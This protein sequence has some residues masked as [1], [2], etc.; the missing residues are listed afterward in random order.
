MDI[1]LFDKIIE[2]MPDTVERIF[3]GGVGEPL[4]HPDIIYMLSE[5]K[6]T[7]RIVEIITNATLIDKDVSQKLIETKLDMLWISLDSIEESCDNIGHSNFAD[8]M[9]NINIFNKARFAPYDYAPRF[10][11]GQMQMNLG[12]AFVLMKDNKDQLSTLLKKIHTLGISKLKVS[13]IIPYHKSQ[14]DQVCYERV[15][16]KNMY[17]TSGS[18]S[19]SIDM[20]FMDITDI[21]DILPFAANPSLTFSVMGKELG[22]DDSYC[23]FVEEGV[24]FV[25]WDGEISPC[26]ALL[27]ENTIHQRGAKYDVE[28][29]IRP[30]S[31][32]NIKESSIAEIWKNKTY[33]RFRQR[34]TDKEFPPCARCSLDLCEFVESNET[35]CASNPFPVCGGCLWAQG[36]IQCP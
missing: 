31:F 2:G 1:K 29:Y 33:T 16:A 35:D 22:I 25:R 28:R 3:F 13:H 17:N 30:C 32:G 5:A 34:V 10:G 14:L 20:P 18:K 8:V 6:K 4:S 19:A 23:R 15:L 24:S 9:E 7:G 12:I 27:H 36:L 26:M 21:P 11:Y